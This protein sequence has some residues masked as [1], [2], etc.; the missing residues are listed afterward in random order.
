MLRRWAENR[1]YRRSMQLA[2]SGLRHAARTR[3]ALEK[4]QSLELAEQKL[5]DALWLRPDA[6][7]ERFR[8][9]LEEIQRSR[10]NSLREFAVPAVERLLEAAEKD[11]ADRATM[12]EPAGELLAYL[13]HYLPD[14]SRTQEMSARFRQL[15]GK[16]PPYRAVPALADMYH[17]PAAGAGCGS[18]IGGAILLGILVGSLVR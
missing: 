16:Q 7:S 15:G 18:L 10:L 17:R 3:N 1:M 5:K 9:G 2:V 6:A 4:L 14:D 13:H 12:L 8:A 11:V